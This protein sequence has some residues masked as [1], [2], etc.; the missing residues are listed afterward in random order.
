M[1]QRMELIAVGLARFLVK[2]I[3]RPFV[4]VLIE[5]EV[6]KQISQQKDAA[7]EAEKTKLENQ[8][9]SLT[10]DEILLVLQSKVG[11]E[12]VEMKD[13]LS[14]LREQYKIVKS[15]ATES[16]MKIVELKEENAKLK[17]YIT[18]KLQIVAKQ[19]QYLYNVNKGKSTVAQYEST[20]QKAKEPLKEARTEVI[21]WKR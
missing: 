1:Q 10:K 6:L 12:L 15:Y 20:V 14:M 2:F 19:V 18:E 9:T 3:V 16:Q 8:Y 11:K 5:E 21:E 13:D 17:L 7:K 4:S